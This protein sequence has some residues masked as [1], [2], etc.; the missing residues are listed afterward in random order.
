MK[1]E[2]WETNSR[3]KKEWGC[4]IEFSLLGTVSE[5]SDA[6]CWFVW[7]ISVLI[8][9]AWIDMRE[10]IVHGTREEEHYF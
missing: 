9:R 6:W 7:L 8:S 5:H 2:E 4:S 3:K 1:G 10:M